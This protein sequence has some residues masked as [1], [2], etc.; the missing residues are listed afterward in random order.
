MKLAPAPARPS[1][2]TS[3][4]P[5]AIRCPTMDPYL[6]TWADVCGPQ[7]RREACDEAGVVCGYAATSSCASGQIGCCRAFQKGAVGCES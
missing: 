5:V 6:S 7:R 3:L 4:Q 1:P 2:A